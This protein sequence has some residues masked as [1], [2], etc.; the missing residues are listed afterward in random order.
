[1]TDKTIDVSIVIPSYNESAT[2]KTESLAA[3]D[4]YLKKQDYSYEVLVVDDK[5][6]NNT[7]AA[8]REAINNKKHFQL[9]ENAHGGKAVTVMTGMIKSRGK[10]A[11]FTDIDQATP[12]DQLDK[13]LPKFAEG[14]D[15]V[16]G[17]RSSRAGAPLERKL[18]SWGFATLRNITL[19]LPFKDTQ[20]G[21]KGFNRQSI[22]DIFPFML[23]KWQS[24]KKTG[25]AVNAGFDIE[26]LF[27]AKKKGFKIAEVPVQWHHVQ[28]EKQVQVIQDSLEA[29][30]DMIRI[31]MT[32]LSGKYS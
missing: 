31:R 23:K 1:M 19:G 22:E 28:N 25:A 5:S 8:V 21:F 12:I 14:F 18:M 30:R 9:L 13:L 32:D 6:T 10:V 24:T 11:V 17:T 16:I 27:L 20:C 3:I 7:L 4:A 29:V 15:I 2:L 26:T